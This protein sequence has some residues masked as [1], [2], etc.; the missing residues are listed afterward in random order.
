MPDTIKVAITDSNWTLVSS[1]FTAGFIT[2]GTDTPLF[3]RQAS[4]APANTVLDGHL[5]NQP[6]DFVN[7]TLPTGD[8]VYARSKRSAGTVFV[9]EK[10]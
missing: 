6:N 10:S 3:Y 5:L 2:N 9:T 1:S 8:E 7:F 4:S